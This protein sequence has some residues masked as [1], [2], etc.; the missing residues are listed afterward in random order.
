MLQ[1]LCESIQL[2]PG[3]VVIL[4]DCQCLS[5]QLFASLLVPL[6]QV[7]QPKIVVG[8]SIV[9][10][11]V[12]GLLNNLVFGSHFFYGALKMN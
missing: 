10:I 7:D 2:C 4:V 3:L 1:L 6:E 8:L 5:E 12:Y 9:R 11:M